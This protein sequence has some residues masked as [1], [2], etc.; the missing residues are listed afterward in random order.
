M[1]ESEEDARPDEF[2]ELRDSISALRRELEGRFGVGSTEVEEGDPELEDEEIEQEGLIAR[3]RRKMVGRVRDF[4]VVEL[5]EELRQHSSLPGQSDVSAVVDEFG[6]DER[7]LR[8]ARR[9]IDFLYERWFRVKAFDTQ[10][11]PQ[12]ERLLFVSNRSGILPYDGLM[13]AS[14]V[15][16]HVPGAQRPRF[17]VAD[18]L[19]TLPFTQ[20]AIARIGGVRASSDNA[21]RLLE[22]GDSVIAFPE[23]Q[24]GAVKPFR[25][26]YRLQRFG[27]GGFVSL[28][29]RQR[30][31]IVPVAVVGA[32]EVHPILFQPR[33]PRRI[34]G[35]PVPITPTFPLLGPLGLVPLPSQ[36]RIRFGEP[37]YFDSVEPEAADD[38]LYVNRTRESVRGAVQ[39]LLEEEVR[40]RPAVFS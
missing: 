21:E 19:M 1:S 14:T 38:P 10:N 12:A 17:L 32:E 4:D 8:R 7:Y 28:A 3:L 33:L 40:R 5:Y 30:A 34:L 16:R 35:T 36:W 6:L 20:P 27:R 18:W 29:V 22:K 11:I 25:D 37:F 9:Y 39:T 26:R 13:I 31:I 24:K 23:G 2:E 15:E